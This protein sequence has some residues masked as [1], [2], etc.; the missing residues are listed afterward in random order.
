MFNAP[1]R[2]VLLQQDM[3]KGK[4]PTGRLQIDVNFRSEAFSEQFGCFVVDGAA[5]HVD[6]LEPLGPR[7]GHCIR[8]AVAHKAVI[9]EKPAERK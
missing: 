3:E 6:C 2:S 5:S 1:I 9:L 7:A 4:Q 8:V